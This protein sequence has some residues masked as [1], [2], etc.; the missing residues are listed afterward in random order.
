MT[1]QETLRLRLLGELAATVD[2]QGS[3]F[4]ADAFRSKALLVIA[5]ELELI[6]RNLKALTDR[7]LTD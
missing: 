6:Q 5:L 7:A 3:D 2:H 1:E 4:S